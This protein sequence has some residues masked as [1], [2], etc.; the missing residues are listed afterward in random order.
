MCAQA[1]TIR[2]RKEL[3]TSNGEII[4]TLVVDVIETPK[5]NG[6]ISLSDERFFVLEELYKFSVEKIYKHPAYE[7]GVSRREG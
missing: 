1:E 4:D 3:G 6:I 7:A 2:V 5:A